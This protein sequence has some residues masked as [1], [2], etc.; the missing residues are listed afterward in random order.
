MN[1]KYLFAAMAFWGAA[2]LASAQVFEENMGKLNANMSA[3]DYYEE[4]GFANNKQFVF[5]GD[6]EV[7]FTGATPKNADYTT[8]VGNSAS[9]GCNVRIGDSYGTYFQI[10][11]INTMGMKKPVV[12]FALLKGV[13]RFDG[14]DLV[15]EYSK[16]GVGWTALDFEPLSTEEGSQLTFTY[17][18]TSKLP[19]AENLSIRFR[20]NGNA[21]VFRIDDVCVAP[22]NYKK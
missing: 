22:K 7:Q 8:L 2:T 9:R 12:G 17:R 10:S 5:E 19:N 18:V 15:V 11:G 21:C 14:T 1:I 13:R 4:G 16:D 20:Q 6:A 3:S